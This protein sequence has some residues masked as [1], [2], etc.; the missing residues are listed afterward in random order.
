[1]KAEKLQ[2]KIRGALMGGAIGDAFG[3]PLEFISSETDIKAKYGES[4]LTEYD[5]SYPWLDESQR[6]QKALFSD[7]TQMT[8]YTAE[9]LLEAERGGTPIVPTVCAALLPQKCISIN[10]SLKT[11]SFQTKNVRKV[12]ISIEVKYGQNGR[13]IA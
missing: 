7:D 13:F 1:M 12:I 10:K 8:L 5:L 4:G 2:D 11:F 3:Y 6:F 9:G